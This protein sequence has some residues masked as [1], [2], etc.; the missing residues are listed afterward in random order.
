MNINRKHNIKIKIMDIII[1][2]ITTWSH[3]T[4]NSYQTTTDKIV[5]TLLIS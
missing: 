4:V 1:M 5:L 2:A 3:S